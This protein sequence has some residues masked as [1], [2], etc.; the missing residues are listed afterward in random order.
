[1]PENENPFVAGAPVGIDQFIGRKDEINRI[2]DMINHKSR[3]SVAIIGDG[4][5]GKTSLMHYIKNPAIY[6]KNNLPEQ[7]T[8]FIYQDC[9]T[10]SPYTISN[11]WRIILR[12]L[13]R[14]YRRKDGS[15]YILDSIKE[16]SG[17]SK[18]PTYEI[19]FLLEDLYAEGMFIVLMLDE[20][21]HFIRTDVENEAKTREFLSGL[22]GL[23]NNENR[24][25]SFILST[26]RSLPRLCKNIRFVGSP[27]YNNMTFIEIGIF[28]QKEASQLLSKMLKGTGVNFTKDEM[29]FI[30]NLAGTHPLLFQIAARLV[31]N[32]KS[33]NNIASP[34]LKKARM[35]FQKEVNHHFQDFWNVSSNRMRQILTQIALEKYTEGDNLLENRTDERRTL[36]RRGLIVN[37]QGRFGIF[38]NE[39]KNWICENR[40]QN[41]NELFDTA[42]TLPGS[43]SKKR[44]LPL[45]FISYSHKNEKEKDALVDHLKVLEKAGGYIDL[46]NDDRIGGGEGWEN[47]INKAIKKAK[48]AILLIS[49]QFLGSEFILG[50]EVPKLMQR[51]KKEGLKVIPVIAKACAWRKIRWLNKLNAKPKNG[52]PIWRGGNEDPDEELTKIAEEISEILQN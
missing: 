12:K 50:K 34:D 13:Y 11:F 51:R 49:A 39:F 19:E 14:S 42:E 6:K 48:I 7:K 35:L 26:R 25:L 52:T 3:G 32:I 31:F 17:E 15:S 30:F 20:F 1:M 21:E 33:K 24:A 40:D 16:L 41:D 23:I 47:D 27:F 9:G 5:I 38:S 44:E 45:V 8:I 18:I 36:L 10:I 4:R 37:N 43:R 22:R 28:T 2:F 46:W 29:D